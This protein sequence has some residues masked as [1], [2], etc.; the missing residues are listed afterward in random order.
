MALDLGNRRIG[1]ALGP[2]PNLPSVPLG[3]QERTSLKHDVRRVLAVAGERG[4]KGLV[5]GMP[6]SLSGESG[7]QAGLTRGFIRE[8]RKHTDLPIYTVDE[9]TYFGGSRETAKGLGSQALTK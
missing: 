8:L 1:L 9:K 2:A 3:F 7:K 5:V 6:Y 4:V